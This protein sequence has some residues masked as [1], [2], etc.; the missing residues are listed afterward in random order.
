MAGLKS[1]HTEYTNVSLLC[2]R[3]MDSGKRGQHRV[4]FR[5]P[6]VHILNVNVKAVKTAP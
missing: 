2:V 3:L 1:L 4:E 5:G 6:G